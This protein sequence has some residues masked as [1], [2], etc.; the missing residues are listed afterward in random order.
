MGITY[1][2]I[3]KVNYSCYMFDKLLLSREL[4]RFYQSLAT[5]MTGLSR[6]VSL[7]RYHK[8]FG[9][10]HDND[11]DKSK[12]K[13]NGRQAKLM[14]KRTDEVAKMVVDH[15]NLPMQPEEWI[16]RSR[17]GNFPTLLITRRVPS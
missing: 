3:V 17:W 10:V 9:V 11:K 12:N 8:Y 15:Y 5:P 1:Y 2:D 4:R 14:G 16:E 7:T 13:K 6:Q